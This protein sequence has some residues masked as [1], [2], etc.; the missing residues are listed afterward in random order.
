MVDATHHYEGSEVAWLNRVWT[1]FCRWSRVSFFRFSPKCAACGAALTVPWCEEP[2]STTCRHV[3]PTSPGTLWNGVGWRGNNINVWSL[4]Q[5]SKHQGRVTCTLHCQ[6][7]CG[8]LMFGFSLPGPLLDSFVYIAMV[9]TLCRCV[10]TDILYHFVTCIQIAL[11]PPKPN[12]RR[13][14][15]LACG[16]SHS[17]LYTSVLFCQVRQFARNG[18]N[19]CQQ[20]TPKIYRYSWH[21]IRASHVGIIA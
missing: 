20:R 13:S 21:A 16:D 1:Y 9:E 17:N 14:G 11:N 7:A 6:L 4:H 5:H 8:K 10:N 2:V 15:C 3:L 19:R 18:R 12:I